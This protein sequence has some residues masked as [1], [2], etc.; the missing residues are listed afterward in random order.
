MLLCVWEERE[1]K[2]SA[3]GHKEP[4]DSCLSAVNPPHDVCVGP[5]KLQQVLILTVVTTIATFSGPSH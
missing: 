2:R 1:R 5:V 4:V 3:A